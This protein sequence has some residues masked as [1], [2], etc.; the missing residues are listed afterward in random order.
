MCLN[1]TMFYETFKKNSLVKSNKLVT[2]EYIWARV[3]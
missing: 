2:L 3:A 1:V